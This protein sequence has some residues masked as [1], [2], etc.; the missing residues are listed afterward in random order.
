MVM[1]KFI[2]TKMVLVM[3]IYCGGRNSQVSDARCDGVAN[4]Y[5]LLWMEMIIYRDG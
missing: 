5:I 1:V 3:V 4:H 2:V